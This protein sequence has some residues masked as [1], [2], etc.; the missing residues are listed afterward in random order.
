MDTVYNELYSRDTPGAKRLLATEGHNALELKTVL[1]G[2][3][4]LT[5]YIKREW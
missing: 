5:S 4:K 3:A 1:Q 2:G